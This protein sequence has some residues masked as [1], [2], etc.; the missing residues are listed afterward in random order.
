MARNGRRQLELLWDRWLATRDHRAREELILHYLPLCD[1]VAERSGRFVEASLRPD[2]Y[3]FAALGLIDALERFRPHFGVRFEA[4]GSRRIRGAVGDGVRAMKWLP[5][6]AE[7]RASRIIET[8][9]PVDFQTARTPMGAHLHETISDRVE[10][11]AYDALET[12]ADHAEVAEAVRSLP[13]REQFIVYQHYY[14]HR[15]LASIGRDLGVTE[16][17]VCQLHRRALRRLESFLLER[18]SA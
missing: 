12:A 5:R 11:S 10:G 15:A 13:E 16:S 3:G 9:V 7:R 1:Y 17:R 8:V 2:L 14:C 6:G 4:Y 18:E